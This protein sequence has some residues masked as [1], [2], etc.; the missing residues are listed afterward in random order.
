M[1]QEIRQRILNKS[2]KLTQRYLSLVRL[3]TDGEGNESSE[4]TMCHSKV[5]M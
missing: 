4:K 3:E 5:Y 2:K 1:T